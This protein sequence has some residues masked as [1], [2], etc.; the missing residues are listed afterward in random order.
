MK[1][2]NPLGTLLEQVASKKSGAK[3]SDAKGSSFSEILEKVQDSN[4]RPLNS[5]GTPGEIV[6]QMEL[7]TAQ[8]QVLSRGEETLT[9]LGHLA[10]LLEKP[11]NSSSME[12]MASALDS[13]SNALL[14]LKAELEQ[15]D[16]L[17]KTVDEIAILSMVEK[18]KIT[19]GDYT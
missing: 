5:V 11:V 1:V 12:S 14:A 18:I 15:G 2:E 19:R 6:S 9:L 3:N 13:S 7:T 4:P 17:A 16:P 10:S 8:K